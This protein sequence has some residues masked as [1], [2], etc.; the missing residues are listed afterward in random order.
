MRK[1]KKILAMLMA[2]VMVMGMSVTAFAEQNPAAG[3]GVP[4]PGDKLKASVVNI[5][6]KPTTNGDGI[7]NEVT[8]TAYQIVEADYA[9]EADNTTS[10]GLTGYSWVEGT[11]YN[12][13]GSE[14]PLFT[15]V[16]T[17][18]G[19]NQ[20]KVKTFNID[21]AAITELAKKAAQADK[22]L[23]NGI[24]MTR[25]SDGTTYSADLAPGS[26][27]VLVTNSDDIIYNPMLVGVYYKVS[28]TDNTL[29]TQILASGSSTEGGDLSAVG[30]W[31]LMASDG[32]AKST[33]PTITK[34]IVNPG[35]GNN[36]GDDAAIGDT[37]SFK[38]TT[39]MPSYSDQYTAPQFQISD[40][41]SEGLEY[42]SGTLKVQTIDGNDELADI[43]ADKY[44]LTP[45]AGI[46]ANTQTFTVAF[47]SDYIQDNQGID[48]V[49]T[50][51]AKLN[52]KAGINF[53]ANTN[54][55]TLGYSHDPNNQ[56]DLK[57][58]DDTTYHYTF[59]IDAAINGAGSTI[60]KELLKT[61]EVIINE[62]TG[63]KAGLDGATFTLTMLDK[64][65]NKTGKV[66]TTISGIGQ[67]GVDVNAEGTPLD[68]TNYKK[69]SDGYL[70][71]IGLDSGKY[72]LEE[73]KAPEG[74]SLNPVQI[75]VEIKA[76]YN[77]QEGPAKGTLEWYQIIVDGSVVEENGK[78]KDSKYEL[79]A[80][81]YEKDDTTGTMIP[82]E[83][84]EVSSD[85]QEIPNTKLVQLPSTG[86]IGTTIF[87]IGGCAIMILAA[88]LFFAS[89]R[90]AGK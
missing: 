23:G 53:D 9:F 39:K 69:L 18:E 84:P 58:K 62:T 70:K 15:E 45:G 30:N 42:I 43:A 61:G 76:E 44:T 72:I 1:M 57:E 8:V 80:D 41:I 87:T 55:A 29:T 36:H 16:T 47:A 2:A 3:S 46:S 67:V 35:S 26:Y 27:V 71:F 31:E 28:G 81:K 89:R 56:T 79:T 66:Y 54:T 60:T 7:S 24:T 40:R 13:E 38:I 20:T 88:G 34:E 83:N 37:V 49:I 25:Q 85:T 75:P 5:K 73:T 78:V 74:Y 50:Y 52:G 59:G 65:G 21:E 82:S 33:E 10:R 32:Y 4:S 19:A 64:D 11:G 6:A 14:R 51:D 63:E 17:G 12:V 48:I 77:K 90:K 68:G 22:P 86:G